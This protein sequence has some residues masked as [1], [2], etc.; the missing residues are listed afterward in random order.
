MNSLCGRC[1][2]YTWSLFKKNP[3]PPRSKKG[4]FSL[5]KYTYI[6]GLMGDK[7]LFQEERFSDAHYSKLQKFGS[8]NCV[9]V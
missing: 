7:C 9:L 8:H 5:W 3:N 4:I 6:T 2:N 1:L